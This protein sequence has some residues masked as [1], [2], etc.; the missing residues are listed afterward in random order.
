MFNRA[1]EDE[2]IIYNPF[3]KLSTAVKVER[4][5]HYVTQNE[6]LSLMEFATENLKP[7]IALCRLAGLRR[8][9]ALN[10]EWCD[11]DW[12]HNRIRIIAKEDWQP[13]DK[14][15][16]I[17]PMCPELQAILSK[18][19]SDAQDGSNKVVS[20]IIVNNIWRDFQVLRRRAGVV[21]YS[22]PFHTLRKSCIRDWAESYPAHVV[23]EWAG[24]SSLDVTDKYYLQVPESE[25]DRASNTGL[26]SKVTQK[27]T[28]LNDSD[29]NE[30]KSNVDDLSQPIGYNKDTKKAGDGIRTHDIQ[31]GKLTFYH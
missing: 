2:I 6:Y 9:E 23:K 17:V 1:V 14:E 13:K 29:Q 8:G 24:H 28:Q 19:Y 30:E 12:N 31:L 11:I 25:Y 27:V 18:V 15:P 21:K 22:K 4:N 3:D 16:R 5:W 26:W 10:L 7:L 20:E